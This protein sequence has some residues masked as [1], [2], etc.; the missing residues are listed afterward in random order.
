MKVILLQDIPKL[1]QRHDIKDVADGF[2]RNVLLP[3]GKVMLATPEN[4]AKADRVR[5]LKSKQ[6]AEE[7]QA[8]QALVKVF[9][10]EPLTIILKANQDGHLFASLR[11]DNVVREA[12]ACGWDIK[13]EWI[14]LSQPIKTLGDHR[15]DLKKGDKK[16]T[17]ILRLEGLQ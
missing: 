8:F 15:L 10:I 16:V 9:Q 6:E 4:L 11:A 1:G 7:N 17:I 2:A 13:K 12:K 5:A 14:V 3:A